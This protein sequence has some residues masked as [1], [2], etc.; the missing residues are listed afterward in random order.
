MRMDDV[1]P[2][3]RLALADL[4]DLGHHA[5]QQA[6][7]LLLGQLPRRAGQD[8]VDADAGVGMFDGGLRWLTWTG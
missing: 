7:Q 6:G 1:V 2:A 8:V 4:L 5:V 3:M